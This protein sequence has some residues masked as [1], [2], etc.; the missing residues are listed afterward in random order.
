MHELPKTI[1][2]PSVQLELRLARVGNDTPGATYDVYLLTF[3][4][5]TFS[6]PN[7]EKFPLP[8]PYL[9]L[10]RSTLMKLSLPSASA[11]NDEDFDYDSSLY[12]CNLTEQSSLSDRTTESPKSHHDVDAT[13]SSR[14]SK[15]SI[16][17]AKLEPPGTKGGISTDGGSVSIVED[18]IA[19]QPMSFEDLPE[20]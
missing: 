12:F 1:P 4:K 7:A 3:A 13:K 14:L 5:I 2:F 18:W 9:L 20:T 10:I 11:E 17:R 8:D 6:T 19:N 15:K 16:E